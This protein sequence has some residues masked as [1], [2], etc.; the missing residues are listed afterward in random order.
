MSSEVVT[1]MV[2]LG[3]AIVGGPLWNFLIA[4]LN[5][6]AAK[7]E[8]ESDRLR[9]DLAD[10]RKGHKECLSRLE[11]LERRVEM[12][13]HHHGSYLARWIVQDSSRRIVWLN[14]QALIMIFAPLGYSRVDVV[15]RRFVDLLEADAAA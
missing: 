15:G 14:N 8:R 7:E 2:G 1:A 3:G 12:V 11:E 6:G 9:S 13:E 4:R 5:M 10:E